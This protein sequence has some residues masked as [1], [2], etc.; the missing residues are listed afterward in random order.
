MQLCTIGIELR[1][2]FIATTIFVTLGQDGS[3]Q[4]GPNLFGYTHGNDFAISNGREC[5]NKQWQIA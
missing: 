1:A 3:I 4:C 5:H 2:R